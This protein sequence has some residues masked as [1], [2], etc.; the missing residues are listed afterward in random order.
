MGLPSAGMALLKMKTYFWKKGAWAQIGRYES[1]RRKAPGVRREC[2]QDGGVDNVDIARQMIE[3][4]LPR[5]L[6]K[7]EAIH[8]R[9][10]FYTTDALLETADRIRNSLASGRLGSRSCVHTPLTWAFHQQGC[11]YWKWKRIFERKV[12]GHR[13]ADMNPAD[14]R[15]RA[16]EAIIRIK[17]NQAPKNYYQ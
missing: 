9:W 17:W 15:P 14:G 5:R 16:L 10:S 2:P 4:K 11:R 7:H 1:C 13:L 6:A 8:R 12:P 3:M